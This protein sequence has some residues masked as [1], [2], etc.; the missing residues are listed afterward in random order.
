LH[1]LTERGEKRREKPI[2]TLHQYSGEG[3]EE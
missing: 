1:L 3:W 2:E